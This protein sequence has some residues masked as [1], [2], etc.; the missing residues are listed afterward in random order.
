MRDFGGILDRAATC[1]IPPM[2]RA[3]L[4]SAVRIACLPVLAAGLLAGAA[5]ADDAPPNSDTLG[6]IVVTATKRETT[7]QETPISITAES[8]DELIGRGVPDIATLAASI[9]GVSLQ[10]VGPGRTNFNIRGLSD[11]GGSS[12]TVGFYLDDVPVSPPTSALSAAGKSELSPDLYD[13][14]RVEVLR[15]PQGTL[16][17]AGSEGGTIRLLTNQP[18][19]EKF[20]AS[21]Q[22]ILGGTEGGGFNHGVNAMLNLPLVEHEAALRLVLTDRYDSG[23]IDRIVVS[24]YPAYTDNNTVRGDVA[25][26]PVLANFSDVNYTHTQAMRATLLWQPSSELSITPA[27]FLQK[28][29]QGGQNSIDVPPGNYAHYQ[30]GNIPESFEEDFE[31]YSLKIKYDFGWATLQSTTS[32]LHVH[33]LN[34]EDVSEQWYGVFL[35]YGSPFLTSGNA[36]EEHEQNQFS[37]EVRLASNKGGSLDWILGAFYNDFNDQLTYTEG[38]SQL[39]PYDG[40]SVV[41]DDSEPD[42]LQQSALFGEATYAIIPDVKVTAGLRYF[43]YGFDYTQNYSGLATAP[44]Y[45]SSGSTSASG[46][47]PK[48]GITYLPT[49]DLTLFADAAKGFRP[50]SANLP[51]PPSFCGVDLQTLGVSTYRPDSVWSYELGEKARLMDGQV[52]IRS[53]IYYIKWSDVQQ[54]IPLACGY[55]YTANAGTAVSKGGEFEL[56]ARVTRDLTLH[57][58][59]GYTDAAITEAA[60]DSVLPVGSPLADVPKW[61]ASSSLEYSH[62]LSEQYALTAMVEDQYVGSEFDP[63]AEPYPVSTRPSYSILNARIGVERDRL[64]AHL[65]VDNALNREA[66]VGFDRS[67]AQNSPQYA[68]EIPTRPRTFGLDVQYHLK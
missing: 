63:S 49:Q 4:M 58:S 28:I 38:S 43:H 59:L 2:E 55:G 42:H 9:P 52:G 31:V 36:S 56:D 60:P 61:T 45:V 64:S 16:Y 24:P 10:S 26:A 37:E 12:P 66:I 47:T 44:P 23:Y 14:E 20:D 6:E 22:L 35:P 34:V 17:G 15:G 29:T 65:F 30:A 8:G 40:A 53:S 11:T 62:P 51:I 21:G 19:L 68:R 41:F 50:G 32:E 33:L 67:E 39:I 18:N 27:V 46:F 57:A 54:N 7:L 3:K 48:I 13:L 5:L 1:R 25:D